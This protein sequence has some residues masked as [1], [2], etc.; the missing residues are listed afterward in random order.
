M[1]WE[2]NVSSNIL[3]MR[4]G[5][6]NPY[7]DFNRWVNSLF[8]PSFFQDYMQTRFGEDSGYFLTCYLRDWV[9][10]TM[11][12][13]LTAGS[14]HVVIY[15]LLGD[16]IFTSKGRAFPSSETIWNQIKLA[17]T[18]MPLYA[19]LPVLSEFLIE[20]GYTKTYF[21]VEEVGGLGRYCLYLLFYVALVEVGIYW[22]HRTLHTNKFL[23]KYV[24]GLHHQYNKPNTLTPWASV[25][26]NPLDGLLQASP[27]V[28]CL[29]LVPMHYFTHMFLL[30]FS[31]VWA[32]NIH[33]SVW[34]DSEPILG[35]KYHTLHH[36]HYHYNYGQ[37]F[38]HSFLASSLY[39]C[40]VSELNMRFLCSFLFS[41][42]IF[43][44]L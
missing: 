5:A 14:W 38:I 8:F 30:F 27:Y 26:F 17:Q 10:G 21:Y 31:G 1:F 39:V 28:L 41:A 33:D 9:A 13:W 7:R 3:Q 36:T 32:T 40:N 37:V 19:A 24:H 18:S 34:A 16:K 11:V 42:T 6:Y 12:Y 29:F 15:R 44:G 4:L 22:M 43:S 35:A 23:Y 20:S 25:A 2:G